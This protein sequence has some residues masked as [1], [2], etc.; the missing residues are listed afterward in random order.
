MIVSCENLINVDSKAVSLILVKNYEVVPR[1]G[2]ASTIEIVEKFSTTR[3][4]CNKL[5]LETENLFP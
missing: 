4:T 5:V 1:F 2:H 3:Q